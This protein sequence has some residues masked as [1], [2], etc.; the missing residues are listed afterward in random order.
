MS[1]ASGGATIVLTRESRGWRDRARSYM[2]MLDDA[3]V[4]KVR[5]GQRVELPVTPGH[6]E[7]FLKISWCRSPAV[8]VDAQPGDVI[9]LFC[10]PGGS[11]S[12]GLGDVL[13]DSQ[14]YITLT[15]VEA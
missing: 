4:A 1:A 9:E 6:H 10:A 14:N 5:R 8:A 3:E 7:V 2:V 11:A 13:G 12:E 15:R